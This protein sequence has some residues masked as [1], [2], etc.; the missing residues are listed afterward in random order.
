MEASS[1]ASAAI[2]GGTQVAVE[3]L[4]VGVENKAAALI[5]LD[6]PEA[7]NAIDAAMLS[8]LAAALAEADEDDEVCV[9]L[10]SG[11]GA[12]F[13]TGIDA[14][15]Y[16]QLRAEPLRYPEF[17]R[18]AQRVFRSCRDIR[19][20]VVGLV[21]GRAI[22]LGL[23][24]ALWCDFIYCAESASFSSGPGTAGQYGG[25]GAL[26]LLPRLAGLAYARE[27]VFTGRTIQAGEAYDHG[28]V[29]RV[30]ADDQLMAAA[31]D[32]AADTGRKFATAIAYAKNVINTGWH[33]GLGVDSAL[34]LELERAARYAVAAGR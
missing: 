27:L 8:G 26:T 31:L 2:A 18:C 23:E 29:N 4:P 25:A 21:R 14:G 12:D 7:G 24:L 30:V 32:L 6:R 34:S 22:G 33:Q 1:D 5:Y 3:R 28:I 10:I 17:L 13:C 19:K 15:S 16:A 11:R 9:V 20:P